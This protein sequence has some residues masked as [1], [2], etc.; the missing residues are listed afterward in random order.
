[1]VDSEVLA[2][3]HL[4]QDKP[5][6]TA[7]NFF[8]PQAGDDDLE[9]SKEVNNQLNRVST[10]GTGVGISYMTV[11]NAPEAYTMTGTYEVTGSEIRLKV[12]IKQSKAVVHRFEITGNTGNLSQL[13]EEL[14]KKVEHWVQNKQ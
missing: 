9:L 11:T 6:F 3:I 10:R 5:L 2:N 7:S 4:P 14:L 8:N 13:S 1:M 12:N